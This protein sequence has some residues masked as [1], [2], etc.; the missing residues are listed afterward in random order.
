MDKGKERGILCGSDAA[1]E[2]LL[3][4]W[5]SRYQEHNDF[6]VAF[7]DFGMTKEAREW[8]EQKGSVI[9]IVVEPG[10]VA[11]REQIASGLADQWESLY[12]KGLWKAR[13]AWFKKPGALLATPFLKTI[14]IDID[15]E[16]LDSVAPLFETCSSDVPF[17]LVREPIS[18]DLPLFHPEVKY[19]GGVI[20]YQQEAA[21]LKR[22]AEEALISS[23]FFWG[24]D[25]MLSHLISQ[26]QHRVNEIS[27]IWNWRMCYGFTLNAK[28]FHWVG[29]GGKGFIRERGGIKP[30]LEAFYAA[31]GKGKGL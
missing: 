13:H 1:Q 20:V 16:I 25:P 19:N 7:C 22:W 24:D 15:C 18:A 11:C 4:W 8:C 31:C 17:A 29:S 10:F 26:E 23:R 21:L 6:P 30:A 27:E 9:D 5:W 14:W 3:P 12:G 28:I 2:W